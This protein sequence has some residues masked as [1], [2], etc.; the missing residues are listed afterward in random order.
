[1]I[2]NL[3]FYDFE[4]LMYNFNHDGTIPYSKWEPRLP[5][6]EEG[7]YSAPRCGD[8]GATACNTPGTA[9]LPPN[10]Q[11]TA[12]GTAGTPTEEIAFHFQQ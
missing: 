8:A 10:C 7:E 6:P 4:C 3:E 9:H 11:N 2:S 12:P 1:M 5:V